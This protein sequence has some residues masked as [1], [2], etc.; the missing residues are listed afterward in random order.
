MKAERHLDQDAVGRG[1]AGA[2]HDRRRRREAHGA[3][4]GD[5]EHGD[6]EQQRKDEVVALVGQPAPREGV[7]EA[8]TQQSVRLV[9]QQLGDW[10]SC[11]FVHV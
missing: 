11:R 3:G 7:C 6:A 8:C 2:H 5:D 4:A 1:D 10:E 9:C